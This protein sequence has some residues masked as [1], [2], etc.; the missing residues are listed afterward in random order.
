MLAHDLRVERAITIAGHFDVDRADVGHHRLGPCAVARIPA[1]AALHRVLLITDV[2]VHL[3]L[4][5]GLEHPAGQITEQTARAREFHPL[6]LGPLDEL[7]R[8]LRINHTRGAGRVG[9]GSCFPARHRSPSQTRPV[10]PSF[11]QTPP[12]RRPIGRDCV[13]AHGVEGR[14]FLEAVGQVRGAAGKAS[15]PG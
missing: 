9:H 3:T 11:R 5:T 12:A 14:A 1:V 7:L 2:A 4:E 8:E 15:S 13:P 6:S 10:T